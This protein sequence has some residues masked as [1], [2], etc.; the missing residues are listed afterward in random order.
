[1][2][3]RK[4]IVLTDGN[5]DK[6]RRKAPTQEARESQLIALAY[7]AAEERLRNGTASSQEITHL[8]K[9]GSMRERREAEID[10]LRKDLLKAKAEAYES[11]K[12]ME[13]LYMDAIKAVQSYSSPVTSQV[14]E[15]RHE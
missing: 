7:D 15:D 4:A 5:D 14:L 13:A 9:M 10:E 2:G 11:A 12:R 1:M 8:L 3:K 6:P